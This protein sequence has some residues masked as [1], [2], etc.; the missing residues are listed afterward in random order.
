MN[1]IF[2]DCFGSY[3]ELTS[4]LC[5]QG[6]IKCKGEQ[7]MNFFFI[8]SGK[9]VKQTLI[10]MVASFFTAGILYI[11]NGI[12]LPVFSTDD[13]PRAIYKGEKSEKKVALTFDISW[14]DTKA[15]PILDT[16]KKEGVKNATFFLSASWAERHPDVVERIL[17]DGH[18][19]GSM[20]YQFQNYTDLEEEKIKRDILQAQ[21]VF[22]TLGVK[23]VVLLRPPSGNFDKKVLKVAESIGY[24]V[25]HWSTNSKDYTNPGVDNIVNNVLGK[26]KGGDIVLLHA[27]DRVK[28]T[29]DA[30]PQIIK[31][32]RQKGYTNST[33]TDIISNAEA[34]NE[35][36]K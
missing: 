31:G 18:E 35:E 3:L 36:V 29:N 23:N 7:F 24:T 9:K 6:D 8:L 15:I 30:L 1:Q 12:Q 22:K 19:V 20:G 2:I 14:G 21:E 16:L 13:G 34:K 27:S 26:I 11:E 28:Q 32:I 25:V 33:V 4:I 17:K 10:I 5:R